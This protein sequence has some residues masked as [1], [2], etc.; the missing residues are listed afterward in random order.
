MAALA[1]ERIAA[2][3]ITAPYDAVALLLSARRHPGDKSR[4]TAEVGTDE[5]AAGLRT[6]KQCTPGFKGLHHAERKLK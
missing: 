3:G 5:I 4:P 2:L 6:F 1:G